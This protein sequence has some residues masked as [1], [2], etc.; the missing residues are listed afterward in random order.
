MP[1]TVEVGGV[2]YVCMECFLY[3]PGPYPTT[4]QTFDARFLAL[5]PSDADGNLA[6]DSNPE[7]AKRLDPAGGWRYR[8]YGEVIAT[9]PEAIVDCGGLVVNAGC[10]V[11]DA[12][13][14]G[15]FLAFE[16]ER[17]DCWRATRH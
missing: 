5:T 1:A 11:P 10:P 4:G 8:A 3:G 16:I 9:A 15:D 6:F 7:N 13:R 2:Q 17:L 14:E 12:V